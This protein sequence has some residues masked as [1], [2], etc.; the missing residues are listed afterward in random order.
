MLLIIR[1]VAFVSLDQNIII[2]IRTLS[3]KVWPSMKGMASFNSLPFIEVSL[4]KFQEQDSQ[5][6]AV[7]SNRGVLGVHYYL[8]A[9]V[10]VFLDKSFKCILLMV[11]SLLMNVL[12]ISRSK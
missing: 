1:N 6:S 4:P 11:A 5:C 8:D 9:T 3:P 7:L 12:F 10:F 2:I